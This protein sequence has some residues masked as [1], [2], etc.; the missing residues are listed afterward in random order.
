MKTAVVKNNRGGGI[1]DPELDKFS[2]SI[3]FKEK[4]ESVKR[5]LAN[6]TIPKEILDK[7]N[8][9]FEK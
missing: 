4:F 9:E 2:G 7:I 8:R 5:I 6:T 1:Y 3:I